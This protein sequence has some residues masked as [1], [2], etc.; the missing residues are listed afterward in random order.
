MELQRSNQYG[1]V[2]LHGQGKIAPQQ[3]L[4][5]HQKRKLLGPDLR[6][7]ILADLRTCTYGGGTASLLA[8]QVLF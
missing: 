2:L 7:E 1:T 5:P 4:L 6:P 3:L 8:Q